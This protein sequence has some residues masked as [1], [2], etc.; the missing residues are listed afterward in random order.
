MTTNSA[1]SAFADERVGKAF[2]VI[3]TDLRKCLVCEDLF[4]RKQ[5][6][7]HAQTVCYPKACER[8]TP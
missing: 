4:T 7:K 3:A 1:C 5:A 8:Q 2:T 6:L